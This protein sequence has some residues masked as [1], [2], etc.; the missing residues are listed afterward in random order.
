MKYSYTVVKYRHDAAAGEVLNVAVV[1]YSPETGQVGVTY[2]PRFSRL[3]EAFADFDG[4]LYRA[5][6]RKL[7]QG[8]A[9]LA[10][11]MSE[12]L[13][14]MEERERYLDVGQVLRAVWPDQGLSYFAGPVLFGV[15]DDLERERDDLHDRFVVS[16]YNRR[17]T[18]TRFDDD[19]LW[20]AFRKLLTPRGIP[21]VLQPKT[22]G[23]AEV[24]FQHAYKNDRWHLIEPASL[25][26]LDSAEIKRKAYQIA[27]KATAIREVEELGSLT[28]LLARPKRVEGERAYLAAKRILADVPVPVRL[29]EEEDAERFADAL[30]QELRE[31][32]L[33][34]AEG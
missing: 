5:V 31:H 12:G 13:F 6:L 18:H 16:Q 28:V 19:Q 20:D 34:K 1:L 14:Q 8:V 3:S 7:E 11:P 27:G 17:D 21:Q 4:D 33:L 32:G 25:D 23:P 26:Y 29:V 30:E 9:A 15:A 10:R 22:L 24:E 2:S